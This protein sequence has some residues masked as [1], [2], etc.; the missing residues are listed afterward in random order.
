MGYSAGCLAVAGGTI[1]FDCLAWHAAVAAPATA[2]KAETDANWPDLLLRPED[3]DPFESLSAT[4]DAISESA[5]FDSVNA[6]AI[7]ELSQAYVATRH[8]QLHVMAAAFGVDYVWPFARSAF[9][10]TM[11]IHAIDLEIRA[12]RQNP[13][14]APTCRS[15]TP[16]RIKWSGIA[17]KI[18]AMPNRTAHWNQ[19]DNTPIFQRMLTL[20]NN[21]P[22]A[23]AAVVDI[24]KMQYSAEQGIRTN[25]K[26][27]NVTYFYETV[28]GNLES[29]TQWLTR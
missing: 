3:D 18:W 22:P 11:A 26:G 5:Q 16:G 23:I 6:H 4:G 2:L 1:R 8:G 28:T 14:S 15:R 19:L 27:A 9:D 25:R 29:L 24:E 17:V 13:L 10:S 21:M 20:A 12:V 7:N